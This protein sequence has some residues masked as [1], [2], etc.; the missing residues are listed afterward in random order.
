MGISTARPGRAVGV[1]TLMIVVPVT[2]SPALM[3]EMPTDPD[4]GPTILD[5]LMFASMSTL[6]EG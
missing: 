6:P 3:E 1:S 4:L 2:P 5:S